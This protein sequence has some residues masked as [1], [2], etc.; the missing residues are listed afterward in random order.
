MV[1]RK[2]ATNPHPAFRD[3]GILRALAPHSNG[4]DRA[5]HHQELWTQVLWCR[6]LA[7]LHNHQGGNGY[8]VFPSSRAQDLRAKG[9]RRT[10]RPSRLRGSTRPTLR[11]PIERKNARRG[12]PMGVSSPPARAAAGEEGRRENQR[13]CLSSGFPCACSPARVVRLLPIKVGSGGCEDM[14]KMCGKCAD[15]PLRTISAS[16]DA[17]F[18]LCGKAAEKEMSC[19]EPSVGRCARR[20]AVTSS[21]RSGAVF[22]FRIPI[23]S[24]R[25]RGTHP[26][27][28]ECR[29]ARGDLAARP[30]RQPRVGSPPPRRG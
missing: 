30:S 3:I 18:F 4:R 14:R 6:R 21:L 8:S 19:F 22:A 2:A 10:L 29:S 9:L 5:I 15:S 24:V 16:M 20:S 17:H 28:R 1:T 7:C 11:T 13:S 23:V 26:H 27:D 25:E 12:R